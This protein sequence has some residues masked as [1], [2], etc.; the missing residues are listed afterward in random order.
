MPCRAALRRDG[1][2]PRINPIFGARDSS[3]EKPI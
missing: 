3:A 1:F 2:Q